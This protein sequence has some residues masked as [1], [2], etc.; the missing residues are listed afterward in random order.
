MTYLIHDNGG[1]PF[2]CIIDNNNITICKFTPKPDTRSYPIK[3]INSLF[4]FLQ[5]K[6]QPPRYYEN[7]D[8]I[9]AYDLFVNELRNIMCN[10]ICLGIRKMTFAPD[11]ENNEEVIYTEFLKYSFD[12]IFIGKSNLNDMTNYNSEYGNKFDGNS[13]LFSLKEEPLKYMFVGQYIYTFIAESEIIEYCSPVGNSNVPYPYAIDIN[14][15]YYLM[16]EQVHLKLDD[17]FKYDPYTEYYKLHKIVSF[18]I[19]SKSL[20]SYNKTHENISHFFIDDDEYDFTWVID[21][22]KD[23]D[24]L[25][26]FKRDDNKGTEDSVISVIDTGGRHEI[27]TKEK[28]INIVESYGKKYGFVRMNITMICDRLW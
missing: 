19:K 10:K 3:L 5:S 7:I 22:S 18:K 25:L 23:Y 15:N 24:R 8:E 26:N 16:I 12:K 9:S 2:K 1:R 28:Y 20:P 21:P 13:I 17:K 14:G 27:L 4:G 6:I 11:Y